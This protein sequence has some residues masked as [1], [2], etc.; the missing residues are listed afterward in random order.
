MAAAACCLSL[1]L[2][3]AI[4]L[5]TCAFF[6]PYWIKNNATSECFRGLIYNSDCSGDVAGLGAA[7]LGLQVIF[8]LF[9]LLTTVSSV[10]LF[11]CKGKDSD[12]GCCSKICGTVCCLRS[13]SGIFGFSGCM[14]IVA[15]YEDHDKGWAF[16]FSLLAACCVIAETLLCC[17]ASIVHATRSES[18]PENQSQNNSEGGFISKMVAHMLELKA[19]TCCCALSPQEN[20]SNV[21]REKS[22]MGQE[23]MPVGPWSPSAGCQSLGG[24]EVM[25]VNSWGGS[26]GCQNS[27]GQEV[28]P[29]ISGGA[30]AGHLVPG[31]HEMMQVG[32]LRVEYHQKVQQW[33]SQE[34]IEVSG[35]IHYTSETIE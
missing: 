23:V 3:P 2:L 29:V 8:F 25:P 24:Q 5:Q 16:Y 4:V 27:R 14:V 35:R 32:V 17:C 7:I 34:V 28:M 33:V 6:S 11:C 30:S 9:I 1:L 12:E 26:A 19:N 13:L 21:N 31:G 20:K 18:Y 10:Y 22:S 15:D